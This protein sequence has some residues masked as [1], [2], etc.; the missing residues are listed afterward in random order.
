MLDS[1]ESVEEPGAPAAGAVFDWLEF[2]QLIGGGFESPSRL[3]EHRPGAGTE[4]QLDSDTSLDPDTRACVIRHSLAE[5]PGQYHVR[6]PQPHSALGDSG[7]TRVCANSFGEL[8]HRPRRWYA[9]HDLDLP[10]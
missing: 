6:D 9:G 2:Q 5:H 10:S 7:P 4:T 3:G 1:L 8:S